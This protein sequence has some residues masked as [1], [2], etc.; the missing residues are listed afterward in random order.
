M[1]T[2]VA[3]KTIVVHRRPWTDV[4]EIAALTAAWDW[5]TALTID[6]DGAALALIRGGMT[7]RAAAYDDTETWRAVGGSPEGPQWDVGV[8]DPTIW[9]DARNDSIYHALAHVFRPFY[10]AHAWAH[11]PPGRDWSK[12]L[13]W[14]VTGV[15]YDNVVSFTDGTSHAFARRERPHL[16]FG[17]G[18]VTPVALSTSAQPTGTPGAPGVD[19]TYTL[20]QPV[21]TRR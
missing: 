15:A 17:E 1:K 20:L 3:G 4:G 19:A 7:W 11:A 10:G 21:K 18:G 6:D 12:P 2:F 9:R 13:D 8:E 5:N 16:V 14:R